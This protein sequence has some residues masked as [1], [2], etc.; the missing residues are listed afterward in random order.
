MGFKSGDSEGYESLL[1]KIMQDKDNTAT[2]GFDDFQVFCPVHKDQVA[3]STYL[4]MTEEELMLLS[5]TPVS[6][7]WLTVD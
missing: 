5:R 4:K 1:Y 3:N 2:I 6:K 7:I